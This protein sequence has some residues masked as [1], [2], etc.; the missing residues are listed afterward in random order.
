MEFGSLW[1]GNGEVG[2]GEVDCGEGDR[3]KPA[4]ALRLANCRGIDNVW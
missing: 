1:P 4:Q 3:R 2:S